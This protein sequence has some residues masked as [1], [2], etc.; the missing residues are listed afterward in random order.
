MARSA[1]AENVYISFQEFW[2]LPTATPTSRLLT[3]ARTRCREDTRMK[4]PADDATTLALWYHLNS[5]VWSN[6]E[7]YLDSTYE[8][9]HKAITDPDA[10]SLA[11]SRSES[12]LT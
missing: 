11:P 12:Q 8:L 5:A 3:A 10:I 6:V 9:N 7:A 1:W 2:D 4:L